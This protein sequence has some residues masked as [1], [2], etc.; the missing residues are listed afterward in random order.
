M[1]GQISV[2][3]VAAGLIEKGLNK[4]SAEMRSFIIEAGKQER[5]DMSLRAS[6]ELTG[7]TIAGNEKVFKALATEIQRTTRYTDEMVIESEALLL[8]MTD[9]N[10]KGVERAIRGAAGLAS[11]MGMDLK[12]ATM[13]VAKAM[14]GNYAALSRYG[15][16]VDETLSEEEKREAI[17]KRL[18]GMYG[19][20]I[21]DTNTY[22]GRVE[23]LKN[24]ISEM[25]EQVGNAVVKNK[26]FNDMLVKVR[27]LI[28]KM[29]PE[30][31]DFAIGVSAFISK[32]A[33][34]A[35]AAIEWIEK[36]KEKIG[37]M[38]S[39]LPEDVK[40]WNKLAEAMGGFSEIAKMINIRL[41]AVGITSDKNFKSLSELTDKLWESYNEVGRTET[42]IAIASGKFGEVVKK[43]FLDIAGEG[44]RLAVKLSNIGEAVVETPEKIR[45]RVRNAVALMK[46]ELKEIDLSKL[47]GGD[48][49]GGV[50]AL[51][52]AVGG[53]LSGIIGK[54]EQV[55]V[56]GDGVKTTFEGIKRVWEAM[57]KSEIKNKLE[58]LR[59]ELE[60]M[61]RSGNYTE[62][63]LE[64]IREA[65]RGLEEELRG[66]PKWVSGF[67]KA[68]EKINEVAGQIFSGFNLIFQTAQRNREIAIENEYKKRLEYINRSVMDEE[69]RQR[70]IEALEAEYE[71]KR[72]SAMRVAA[73][74]QK[75][76]AIMEAM[77]NTATAVSKALA[78]G[79]FLLGIPWAA[80][81]GALGAAQVAMIAAQPIPLAR[82][83]VF[84]QATK[85]VSDRGQVYEMGEAGVEYLLPEKH[86]INLMMRVPAMMSREVIRERVEARKNYV[87]NVNSPLVR[88][89]SVSKADLERV[90]SD[91]YRIIEREAR[92]R[93]R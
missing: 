59:K 50:M 42:L 43:A 77:I 44:G 92:R 32:I 34:V 57:T 10:Q 65:I 69:S 14:E 22:S 31:E 85:L 16:K 55:K 48:K 1:V 89:A 63:E 9:L 41:M 45:T 70:A 64:R 79:G 8:Q 61:V 27:E 73:R 86:L 33:E 24:T 37:G 4:I 47:M 15:I 84:K 51:S 54:F 11:V 18:E 93:G 17:L 68:M 20:A 81:V 56:E 83:A 40:A 82:G 21:A 58:E 90:G 3:V 74:Q 29:M 23:Q 76:V 30:I 19:R 87:I 62:A 71:I 25:K 53:A 78:Q 91:L 75:A 6:L 49:A 52:E 67:V 7:R 13:L 36:T 26:E 28:E 60:R 35:G 5:A 2:A 39:R 38:R 88:A 72:T 46:M 66:T 80:V 12:S